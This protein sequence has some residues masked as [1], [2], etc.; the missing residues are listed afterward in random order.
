MC[1]SMNDSFLKEHPMYMPLAIAIAMK[2]MDVLQKVDI[3]FKGCESISHPNDRIGILV[4]ALT[5]MKAVSRQ[6]EIVRVVHSILWSKVL[7]YVISPYKF[8]IS[9]GD[10]NL[11]VDAFGVVTFISATTATFCRK[12]KG[13][14][15]P[16]F[17]GGPA[18]KT[19]RSQNPALLQ[20]LSADG[21]K[22]WN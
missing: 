6:K 5:D 21:N 2:S 17:A 10:Y 12:V 22:C 1:A 4:K 20:L 13:K 9:S 8:C 7:S 19:P 14:M 16:E 18:M 3:Q 15:L 11:L